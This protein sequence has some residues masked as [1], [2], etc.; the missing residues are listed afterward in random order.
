MK[1]IECRGTYSTTL[2]TAQINAW[3]DELI[4]KFGND[5]I[6]GVIIKDEGSDWMELEGSAAAIENAIDDLADDPRHTDFDVIKETTISSRR[7]SR[8]YSY[9]ELE[10]PKATSPLW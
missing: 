9:F 6:T 1:R 2:T 8:C 5:E 7:L 3:R 10:T 4:L